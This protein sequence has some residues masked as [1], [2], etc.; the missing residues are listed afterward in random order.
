MFW[1]EKLEKFP[2]H[3][4]KSNFLKPVLRLL[5]IAAQ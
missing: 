5:F 4:G 2:E 3:S 1:P